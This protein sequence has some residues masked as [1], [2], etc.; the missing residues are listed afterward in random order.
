MARIRKRREE[1]GESRWAELLDAQLRSGLSQRAFCE[2]EG[3]STS[4]FTLWRRRLKG[5]GLPVNRAEPWVELPISLPPTGRGWEL[6][7]DLGDGV[8]FR[9]GRA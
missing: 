1:L 9:L 3:L 7:L 5:S 4:T 8:V 2:R 6:E